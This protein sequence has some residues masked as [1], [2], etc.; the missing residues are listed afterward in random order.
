MTEQ[1]KPEQV[2]LQAFVGSFGNE[3]AADEA[4]R[5]AHKMD[6]LER[7]IDDIRDLEERFRPLVIG[8]A[9][10]FAIGAVII[11]VPHRWTFAAYQLIGSFGVVAL[12]SGLPLLGAAYTVRVRK[13]SIVDL[14]K[15]ALNRKHFVPHGGY[16]FPSEAPGGAGHVIRMTFRK[17]ERRRWTKWDYVKPGRLW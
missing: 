7:S 14:N 10:A 11:L 9:I 6:V 4:R 3:D 13:R 8:A 16:Y 2:S 5:A 1:T 17:P 12:L 15:I